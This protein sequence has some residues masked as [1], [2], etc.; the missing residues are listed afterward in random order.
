[1]SR[2]LTLRGFPRRVR[3][4]QSPA[5]FES[6]SELLCKRMPA[7][8]KTHDEE[9]EGQGEAHGADGN[10]RCKSGA[11][12]RTENATGYEVDEEPCVESSTAE[13]KRSAN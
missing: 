2:A 4:L 10:A 1:M 3:G 5:H 13:V 11:N 9:P 7:K 12:Q 6:Q 8:L